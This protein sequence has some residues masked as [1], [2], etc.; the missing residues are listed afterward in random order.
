MLNIQVTGA[1]F[2]N[3]VNL[4]YVQTSI[5]TDAF[6][7]RRELDCNGR[8]MQ[9]EEGTMYTVCNPKKFAEFTRFALG[10]TK[11]KKRKPRFGGRKPASI[12][13]AEKRS[14]TG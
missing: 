11:E 1:L 5:D 13:R 3:G 10:L 4:G 2:L 8:I 9:K 12:L 7:S 14:S 6:A